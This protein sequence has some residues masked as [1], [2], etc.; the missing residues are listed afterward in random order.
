MFGRERP[1]VASSPQHLPPLELLKFVDRRRGS[2]VALE[3]VETVFLNDDIDLR[4]PDPRRTM[5]R[6]G[7]TIVYDPEYH[8][9]RDL[10]IRNR[11]HFAHDKRNYEKQSKDKDDFRLDYREAPTLVAEMFIEDHNLEHIIGAEFASPPASVM[12]ERRNEENFTRHLYRLGETAIW[13]EDMVLEGMQA[14]RQTEDFIKRHGYK[15]GESYFESE[16]FLKS[17]GKSKQIIAKS[18]K[19]VVL[20]SYET[21]ISTLDRYKSHSMGILPSA[22]VLKSMDFREAVQLLGKRACSDAEITVEESNEIIMTASREASGF[23]TAA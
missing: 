23:R 15:T 3:K 19:P 7:A 16:S 13:L 4:I 18:Q 12:R 9:S 8:Q 2:Y 10:A 11:H 20:P 14:Y 21:F 6:L 1:R 5:A 17:I 22:E